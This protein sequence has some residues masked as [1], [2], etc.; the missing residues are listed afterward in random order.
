MRAVCASALLLSALWRTALAGEADVPPSAPAPHRALQPV[1]LELRLNGRTGGEVLVMLQDRSGGLWLTA[2]D[3]ARLHLRLPRE[4]VHFE[5]STR[6]FA[7][8]AIDGV[9]L[10]YDPEHSAVDA[11]VPAAA[12]EGS[13]VSLSRGAPAPTPPGTPGLFL[14]YIAYGQR[15]DYAGSDVASLYTETGLFANPGTLTSSAIGTL[16]EGSQRFTRLETTASHDFFDSIATLRLGDSINVPGT[17]SQAVRFGGIQFGSNYA[18]RP[19]LVTTPLLAA[20]GTA[21]VPSSVDVFVNGRQVGSTDVPAGPFVISQVPALT[22]TG[23]VRVVLHDALGQEQVITLPFYSSPQLLQAG[24]TLY[25]LDLGAVRENYGLQSDSYGPLLVSATWRHGFSATLTGEAHAESL[26]GG[27]RAAGVDVAREVGHFGIVSLDLAA[28]G[29]P[30]SLGAYEALGFEHDAARVS[31]VLRLEHASG[32]F[33][34]VGYVDSA[35]PPLRHREFGEVSWA[36][37][38]STHVALAAADE[39]DSDQTRARTVA[40]SLSALAGPG[41]VN[42]NLTR[43]FGSG[44]GRSV[45]VVYTLPLGRELSTSTTARY[46]STQPGPNAALVQTLQKSLPAGTGTGY[47]A[48][49]GTDGSYQLELT[50]QA[51]AVTVDAG[52]ARLG[53]LSA[54]RLSA[55]GAFIYFDGEFT[56]ARTVRDSFALVDMQGLPGITVYFDNQ[57]VART[58]ADGYAIVRDLRSYEVNRLSIDPLQL[59]LEVSL[60]SD[61]VQ[62]VP[63]YRSAA[64]VHF[65]VRR[66]HTAVFHLRQAGGQAVPAGAVVEYLGRDFPV[67]LDGLAYVSGHRQ[68]GSGLARWDG[69]ECVFELPAPPAPAAQPDLGEIRCRAR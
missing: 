13:Q 47:L 14:N 51:D 24:L 1:V 44:A 68:R 50:H 54:Q 62:V 59:P 11:T 31:V 28:G 43:T 3:F 63:A 5:G 27:A 41:S 34:D 23:D 19:D 38:G 7:L 6:Y 12:F 30:S 40:L 69:H 26:A 10:R 45:Y 67:G 25:D 39:V 65:P 66:E 60:D 35:L 42:A 17:W 48:A 52:A 55:S 58:D 15:G 53:D 57:P 20:A 61:R 9:S 56:A 18:M 64:L 8:G 49:L 36:L 46:D 16:A 21:V 33:R 37:T 2:E 4:S 22:G 32:A 29:A